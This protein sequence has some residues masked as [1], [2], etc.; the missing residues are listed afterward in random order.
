MGVLVK[1]EITLLL[2]G[3]LVY[4]A[5]LQ[6]VS[7]KDVQVMM[8][9]GWMIMF[10]S[11]IYLIMEM[12]SNLPYFYG[13]SQSGG[14]NAN[15]SVVAGFGIG[16]AA[17]SWLMVIAYLFAGLIVIVVLSRIVKRKMPMSQ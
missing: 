8:L 15:G 17:S 3:L 13:R 12:R 1:K 9:V 5:K 10:I 7:K 14:S 4:F 6:L 11:V 16:I 2:S